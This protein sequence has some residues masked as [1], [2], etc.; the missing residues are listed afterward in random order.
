MIGHLLPCDDL[1]VLRY[2]DIVMK[3]AFARDENRIEAADFDP[4]FQLAGETAARLVHLIKQLPW[5]LDIMRLLPDSI[6]TAMEPD[7]AGYIKLQKVSRPNFEHF[8]L[9]RIA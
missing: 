9:F 8:H 5:M 2:L 6:Q 3:Y 4:S 1:A 7:M